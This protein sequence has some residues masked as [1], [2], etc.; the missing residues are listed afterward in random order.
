MRV[1]HVAARVSL[2]AGIAAVATA[3]WA[4]LHWRTGSPGPGL[5]LSIGCCIV[6]FFSAVVAEAVGSEAR[7]L[8]LGLLGLAVN[9]LVGAMWFLVVL[10]LLF[11]SS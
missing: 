4:L 9:A 8:R 5:V 11:G 7:A 3:V 10:A 1:S 6:G 2:T